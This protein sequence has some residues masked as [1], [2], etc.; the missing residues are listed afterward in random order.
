MRREMAPLATSVVVLSNAYTFLQAALLL[1]IK[2]PLGWEATGTTSKKKSGHFTHFKL[3][4]SSGFIVMYIITLGILIINEHFTFGPS[5]FIV[6]LFLTSF[7]AHL[8]FLFYTL[9]LHEGT[10]HKLLDRK[11]YAALAIVA[12]IGGTIYGA[13]DRHKEYDIVLRENRITIA[14]QNSV[15]RPSDSIMDGYR[16]TVG[17]IRQLLR[18]P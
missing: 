1:I 16:R 4:A 15:G 18:L 5:L 17:D 8:A 11:T 3:L 2:R 14:P 9:V 10:R 6:C 7:L 12:L 13:S